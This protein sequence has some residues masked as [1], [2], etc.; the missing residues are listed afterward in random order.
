MVLKEVASIGAST[1]ELD[2]LAERSLETVQ[3]L[4]GAT[5]GNLFVLDQGAG[6]LRSLA[7][8]GIPQEALASYAEVPLDADTASTRVALTGQIAKHEAA[9][10]PDSTE[11]VAQV[12]GAAESSWIVLP[13]NV[14]G[15]TL[16]TLGLSFE[17][18]RPFADAEVSLYQSLADQ[19]G[20]AMEKAQL[21]EAERSLHAAEEERRSYAEALNRINA[22][23]HST[24]DMDEML[25][26]VTVAVAEA[27][28]FSSAAIMVHGDGFW[29]FR[30]VT[31]LEIDVTGV[32]IPDA[33]LPLLSQMIETHEMVVVDDAKN[34]PRAKIETYRRFNVKGFIIAPLMARG[35]AEAFLFVGLD[36]ERDR[37]T[38]AQADF[39]RKVAS[40]ISLGIENSRLY[41]SERE[42]LARMETLHELTDLAVSSLR[43][44]D[45]ARRAFAFMA[46]R[47]DVTYV[48]SFI[49]NPAT[50]RLEFLAGVGGTPALLRAGRQRLRPR[51]PLRGRDGLRDGRA[52][53]ARYGSRGRGHW[54]GRGSLRPL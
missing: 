3:S 43:S 10:V 22:I 37:F 44:E 29:T 50:D 14:R 33:D 9:D 53:R 47:L 19:L 40:T 42:R 15:R 26:R 4:L 16:G 46:E 7:S 23:V 24:F 6:V 34:D 52:G 5:T 18:Q 32:R 21:F 35:S 17:Q 48:N 45:V 30:E 49:H 1:L 20:V 25:R 36:R 41:E 13:V 54:T 8:F 31:G 28:N 11:R 51:F 2:E 38:E 12:A 27:V 39:A